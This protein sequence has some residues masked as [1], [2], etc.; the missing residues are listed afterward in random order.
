MQQE[1]KSWLY[2]GT[3]TATILTLIGIWSHLA[4][5]FSIYEIKHEDSGL[6]DWSFSGMV[7][8]SAISMFLILTAIGITKLERR[9]EGA[10]GKANKMLMLNYRTLNKFLI[11][12]AMIEMY[13]N[14]YY[15]VAAHL[16]DPVFT[17]NTMMNID[18]VAATSIFMFSFTLTIMS[19]VG[20]KLLSIFAVNDE[21]E[22]IKKIEKKLAT[23]MDKKMGK[24]M[25]KKME[26]KAPDIGI[27]FAD[28]KPKPESE[29]VAEEAKTEPVFPNDEEQTPEQKHAEPGQAQ[30]RT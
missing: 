13:G 3:L 17:F 12:F 9:A 28:K 30:F 16:N 26:T 18:P 19:I 15:S 20:S 22:I 27:K 24:K 4:T 6:F 21:P 1:K 10:K 2:K 14:I 11:F 29:P 8:A 7:L 5:A 25:G 23:K